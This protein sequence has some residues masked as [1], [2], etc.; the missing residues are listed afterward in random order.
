MES[1]ILVLVLGILGYLL[2]EFFKKPPLLL[3]LGFGLLL[4]PAGFHLISPLHLKEVLPFLLE[5]GLA[6]ILFEGGLSLVSYGLSSPPSFFIPN[7]LFTSL[8]TFF[9][10]GLSAKF[11]LHLSWPFATFL[12]I[13]TLITGPTVINP[14]LKTYPLKRDVELFLHW[15]SIWIDI[16]GILLASVSL[17]FIGNQQLS[18]NFYSLLPITLGTFLGIGSGYLLHFILQFLLKHFKKDNV[19]L[20]TSLGFILGLFFLT[21]HFMPQSGPLCIA[22]TGFILAK[23]KGSY[24]PQVHRF[25]DLISTLTI[26]FLFVLISSLVDFKHIL[27][28][29]A[30][31]L[32]FSL[33]VIFLIRPLATLLGFKG[34]LKEKIFIGLIA[35][36]GIVCLTMVSYLGL[37]VQNKEQEIILQTIFILIVLTSLWVSMG[38]KFLAQKCNIL[39]N[40][41]STG[42]IIAGINPFSLKLGELLSSYVPVAFLDSNPKICSY[43]EKNIQLPTCSYLLDAS[44]YENALL[45][46]YRRIIIVTTDEAI[47]ELTAQ[48]ASKFF[49]PQLVYKIQNANSNQEQTFSVP[50]NTF[51][52]STFELKKIIEQM[53]NEEIVLT[54]ENSPSPQ[55]KVLAKIINSRQICFDL[56][57]KH[58]A[59]KYIVLKSKN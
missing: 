1:L 16:I 20:L 49:S 42:I 53:G 27:E 48:I 14:L 22:L 57:S 41:E 37:I 56:D 11:L 7:F 47:N 43:L 19:I 45:E 58:Q 59:E 25:K 33:S 23:Q 13:L 31:I 55:S 29:F 6:I 52:L 2:G 32:I 9:L 28:N 50:A 51:P 34:K 46:G 40:Y 54:I 36:K 15:E 4:G 17:Q 3:Y 30:P 39:I 44:V 21:E 12:A 10:S 24:L 18:Q 26:S 38:T 8:I 5:G 35:P